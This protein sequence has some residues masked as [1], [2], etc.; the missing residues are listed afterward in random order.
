MAGDDPVELDGRGD[1]ASGPAV[2]VD[3]SLAFEGEPDVLDH[4]AGAH[5]E[6]EEVVHRLGQLLQGLRREGPEGDGP[7]QADLQALLAQPLDGALGDPGADAVGDDDHLGVVGEVGLVADL[8]LLDELELPEQLPVVLF[9][10][11]G[12]EDA[13]SG[14]CGPAGPLAPVRM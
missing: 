11:L 2:E 8:V 3:V 13:G 10:Q 12:V 6:H 4:L 9:L 1:D 7:E 14:S 5:L